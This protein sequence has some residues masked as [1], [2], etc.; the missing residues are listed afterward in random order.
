MAIRDEDFGSALTLVEGDDGLW[1]PPATAPACAPP[2]LHLL[3][4]QE[5]NRAK[6]A[7]ARVQ[8]L[9][10]DTRR[11]RRA[12]RK[13]EAGGRTACPG[14]SARVPDDRPKPPPP[15]R[16]RH[17]A[18]APAK[19]LQE[20]IKLLRGERGELRKEV[21]RLNKKLDREAQSTEKHKETIRR[22]FDEDIKLRAELR[23]RR[24]QADR[25][26]SLTDEAFWLRLSLEGAQARK[27]AL[28][29]KLAKLLTER[30]TL[31]KPIAGPQLRAASE[32]ITAPEEDD[33]VPIQGDPPPARGRAC[34]G[35]Q[36]GGADGQACQT[37]R[38]QE[39]ALEAHRG[40]SSARGAQKI[41]RQKQT[42]T[43]QS[44]EIRRLRKAL[45]SSE[46]RKEVLEPRSPSSAR[47][48][49]HC[50][51]PTPICARPCGGRGAR[52]ARSSP[53]PGRT[54]GC[55][56]PRRRRR[57]GS[58]R[59]KRRS[60]SFARPG[61]RC[62]RGCSARRAR[63]RRSRP[64]GASAVSSVAHPAT[65][66][67]SGPGSKSAGKRKPRRRMRASVP[68]AASPTRRTAPRK[69]PSSRS[70]SRPTSAGSSVPAGAEPASARPRP[71]R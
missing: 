10:N 51:S 17:R 23:R 3:Y 14:R 46:T 37:H 35:G 65:A 52:R 48:E 40:H 24:D 16:R 61:R 32:E 67:P 64:L 41:A 70:R 56:R 31:S 49:G 8:E 60:P 2:D 9:L 30:K 33:P 68:V 4:E 66:A 44:K 18:P 59:W 50:P 22:Q 63:S 43:S 28:Q 6:S 25:V 45:R 21:T 47:S 5:L 36:E 38:G 39:D 27:R 19:S 57:P 53:F 29:A 58:E 20:T 11:L 15:T 54:P 34:V 69:P 62:P 13:T 42:I 7:E 26:R 12:L 71:R 1:S 55:A